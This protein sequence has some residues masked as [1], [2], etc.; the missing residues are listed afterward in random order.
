MTTVNATTPDVVAHQG[1]A[2]QLAPLVWSLPQPP[3]AQCRYDHVRAVTA[4][5]TFSIEWKSWKA[6]D[7][8]TLYVAGEHV[9]DSYSLQEA[10][11]EATLYLVKIF[12]QLLVPDARANVATGLPE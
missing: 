4:L 9:S 8:F 10:K 7:S 3:E 5:G 6:H 2:V 12:T 11:D 1:P